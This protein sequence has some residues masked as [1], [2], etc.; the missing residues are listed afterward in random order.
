MICL[1]KTSRAKSHL[2][3]TEVGRAKRAWDQTGSTYEILKEV[4]CF[5][6]GESAPPVGECRRMDGGGEM[7]VTNSGNNNVTGQG[8]L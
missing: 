7:K 5:C 8:S 2:Q 3:G 6:D 1:P 4:Q